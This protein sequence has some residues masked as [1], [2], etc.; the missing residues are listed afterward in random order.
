MRRHVLGSGAVGR[1]AGRRHAHRRAPLSLG[2]SAHGGFE[3]QRSFQRGA[4]HVSRWLRAADNDDEDTKRVHTGDGRLCRDASGEKTAVAN[5]IV[6]W[7][8]RIFVAVRDGRRRQWFTSDDKM[9]SHHGSAAVL[10]VVWVRKAST[11]ARTHT[12]GAHTRKQQAD[13]AEGDGCNGRS[14]AAAAA[15]AGSSCKSRN[16]G[17]EKRERSDDGRPARKLSRSRPL[18]SQC[19]QWPDRRNSIFRS[20]I[21]SNYLCHCHTIYYNDL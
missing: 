6:G 14:A 10:V 8:R 18:R 13:E 17:H 15:A 4:R 2:R 19:R 12:M 20:V 7:R 21:I 3:I 9:A 11:R 5:A 1:R 16:G